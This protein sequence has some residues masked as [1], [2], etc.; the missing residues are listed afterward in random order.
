MAEVKLKVSADGAQASRAL[1]ELKAKLESMGKAGEGLSKVLEGGLGAGIGFAAAELGEKLAESVADAIKEGIKSSIEYAKNAFKDAELL[2][3]STSEAQR[4]RE[5]AEEHGEE[6]TEKFSK[7]FESLNDNRAKALEGGKEQSAMFQKLF[8]NDFESKLGQSTPELYRSVLEASQGQSQDN[9]RAIF[10]SLFG[11]NGTFADVTA[12]QFLT[13]QGEGIA[14]V[15]DL[16]NLKAAEI[17]WQKLK[18]LFI[19]DIIPAVATLV[20]VFTALFQVAD[21]F[22]KSI[23]GGALL[24]AATRFFLNQNVPGAAFVSDSMKQSQIAENLKKENEDRIKNNGF[25]LADYEEA[26][27]KKAEAD[28]RKKDIADTE[29]ALKTEEHTKFI[30]PE[31]TTLKN[32][33]LI[34][35]GGIMGANAGLRLHLA[36]SHEQ[37]ML[38]YTKSMNDHL[39]RIEE[40]QERLIAL[41]DGKAVEDTTP[42]QDTQGAYN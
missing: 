24:A 20:S 18:N 2:G 16:A 15:E 8:G 13:Q 5:I 38:T 14:G 35:S 33:G 41:K 12:N 37:D 21:K 39:E 4:L 17:E 32:F 29:Q 9:R 31:T 42:M 1:D 23:G 22:L 26:K 7:A 11:K 6:G 19:V 34:A 3:V 40:L 10:R 27:R 28:K 30:K 36:S 25:S